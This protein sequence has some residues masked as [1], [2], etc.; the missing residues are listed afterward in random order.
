MLDKKT[1]LHTIERSISN[2]KVYRCIHPECTYF[3]RV[4]FIIGK[5]MVCKCGN[6]YFVERDQLIKNNLKTPKCLA[7][8]GSK[9]ATKIKDIASNIEDILAEVH[10]NES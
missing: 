6:E 4:D 8:T 7:C 3:A 5:K 10:L 9:K 2:K 1:H